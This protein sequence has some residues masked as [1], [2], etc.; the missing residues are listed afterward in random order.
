MIKHRKKLLFVF[1]V[2]AFFVL[3]AGDVR[4]SLI[5]AYEIQIS[6][7]KL[8]IDNLLLENSQLKKEVGN[9]ATNNEDIEIALEPIKYERETGSCDPKNFYSRDPEHLKNCWRWCKKYASLLNSESLQIYKES[10]IDPVRFAFVWLFKE[11]NFS[12]VCYYHNTNGTIDNGI[13][14]INDCVWNTLYRQLPKEL[15]G[16]KNPKENAEVGI[17]MFYLWVNDR[18]KNKWAFAY[19]NNEGWTLYWRLNEVKKKWETYN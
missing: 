2:F 19:C 14:Q 12:S 15:Q 6:Q 5:K 13:S 11:S 1:G 3:G 4:D 17:A 18:V 8:R 16:Y 10:Q 9:L 7:Q